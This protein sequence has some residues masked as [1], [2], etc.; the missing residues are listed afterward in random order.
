MHHQRRVQEQHQQGEVRAQPRAAQPADG[1]VHV[2][3]LRSIVRNAG[4]ERHQHDHDQH[5]PDRQHGAVVPVDGGADEQILDRLS[6][7][8]GLGAADQLRRDELAGG[9]DQHEHEAG[10]DAGQRQR[11]RD[12]QEGHEAAGAQILR[13]LDQPPVHVLHDHEHRER[14][15]RDPRVGQ[16]QPDREPG[17]DQPGDGVALVAQTQ[18]PQQRVDHA[19][20]VQHHLP[21][22]HA[23]Q[24]AREEGRQQH[25]QQHVAAAV[26]DEGEEVGHRI[27]G[28]RRQQGHQ[29]GDAH[30]L[31]ERV[32]ERRV[33]VPGREERPLVREEVEPVLVRETW[34]SHRSDW[35]AGTGCTS[36]PG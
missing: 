32:P 29:D 2:S 22:Q 34:R 24:E 9:R 4:G 16:H 26:G 19:V 33:G 3:S 10:D 36:R 17:V 35:S 23:Q 13:G 18:L 1:R 31:R 21:R 28:G 30:R 7:H 15:E 5:Q 25:Q 27:G 11:Q 6:E 12:P 8:V 20:V 14:H